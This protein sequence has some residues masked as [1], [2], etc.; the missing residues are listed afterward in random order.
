MRGARLSSSAVAPA[1]SCP[2]PCPCPELGFGFGSE[3]GPRAITPRVRCKRRGWTTMEGSRPSM[4]GSCASQEDDRA[5]IALRS[6][7]WWPIGRA[8]KCV[9]LELGFA[10]CRRCCC[11]RCCCCCCCFGGRRVCRCWLP[12]VVVD[13]CRFELMLVLRDRTGLWLRV[14]KSRRVAM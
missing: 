2:C 1:R 13:E 6:S 11:C 9:G 10:G 14:G 7:G 5:D 12:L 3:L 8:R 4:G